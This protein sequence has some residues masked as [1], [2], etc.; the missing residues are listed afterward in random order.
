MAHVAFLEQLE[1][2]QSGQCCLEADGLEI[3]WGTHA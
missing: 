3:G 2:A 1:Y